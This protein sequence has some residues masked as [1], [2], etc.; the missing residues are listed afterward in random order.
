MKNKALE[1]IEYVNTFY[2]FLEKFENIKNNDIVFKQ[3]TGIVDF[4]KEFEENFNLEECNFELFLYSLFGKLK[5]LFI[6]NITDFL[7]LQYGKI[8][9]ID[10]KDLFYYYDILKLFK[11]LNNLLKKK[12]YKKEYKTFKNNGQNNNYLEEFSFF[13]ENEQALDYL[14]DKISK[15]RTLSYNK[16]KTI[17]YKNFYLSNNLFSDNIILNFTPDYIYKDE[18]MA[19]ALNKQIK[20]YTNQELYY[21]PNIGYI[22]SCDL[23]TQDLMP[24][25]EV[26]NFFSKTVRNYYNEEEKNKRVIVDYYAKYNDDTIDVLIKLKDDFLLK[27]IK[28]CNMSI[29]YDYYN[30][31]KISD[32]DIENTYF[33]MLKV[34]VDKDLENGNYVHIGNNMTIDITDNIDVDKALSKKI[35]EI[36]NVSSIK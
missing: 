6:Y 30:K 21:Y 25:Y 31:N 20:K 11:H 16:I 34:D 22:R 14:I 10:L 15:K 8:N 12:N 4:K 27:I 32:L 18:Y 7:N 26:Y 9:K 24:N 5:E 13:I 33:D 28:H 19:K 23:K 17:N 1:I 2:L 35:Y 29:F 3:K 36:K